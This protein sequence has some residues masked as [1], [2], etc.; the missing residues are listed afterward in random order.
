[1]PDRHDAPT[2]DEPT[3]NSVSKGLLSR[4]RLVQIGGAGLSLT[5]LGVAGA[6]AGE[7]D[8][9]NTI[10][11]D[12]TETTGP[13]SYE[14]LVTDGAAVHPDLGSN[15]S[16][17][18]IDGG[19]VTGDLGAEVHAYRFGGTLSYLDVEGAAEVSLY[20]GGGP[21][22]ATDRLEVV[23]T[24]DGEVD[25][26]I[27]STDPVTKVLSE[28]ERPA[29]ADDAVTET[30]DGTWLVDGATRNGGGDT[31]DFSG[32]IDRFEPV[33]GDF[34]LF[35]NGEETTVTELTGQ[36][37]PE[38]VEEEPA[39][40]NP[41]REH[42]YSFEAT[43]DAY[44]D[45]YIE[46]EDGGDL[47]PSTVDDATVDYEFFW[48]GDGG[49]KA[50]GRV[51]PGETHAYA[52]DTL[53][54]DVTIEGDAHPTVDG[55][56][57]GL[58]YYPRDAASGDHWKGYFPW[59]IAGEERTHWYSFEAT[60]DEYADYYIEVEDGG[61]LIP[62]T[63]DD[64]TVDYEF[65][66]IGDG[67]TKAAGRVQPGETHAYA[68]DTLVADVTI[69]GD[70]HP[71]VNGSDSGLDYYPRDSATGDAWKTGFP[72]QDGD[73]TATEPA[74][75]GVALGGGPG[76]DRIVTRAD[77]D[78]VVDGASDLASAL[79]GASA[80]DVV[81]VDGSATIDTGGRSMDV[82]DGV[83]LASN[84][85][86]DGAPGAL[87]YT[88]ETPQIMLRPQTDARVTGLRLRGHSPGRTVTYRDGI[89]F[90]TPTYALS[91][92]GGDVEVDN[93]EV[94]GWPDRAIA[95][96]R[97]RGHVHHNYIYD[98]NGQGLGY[99]VAANKECLIEY[100]YFHNNRHSVTC[101][102]NAPG[103]TARYNHFSPV[104]VMHIC[105]V[106]DP[107]EG[108][109][110][111]ESN[112]VENGESRTWDNP[113]AEGVAGYSGGFDGGSLA[114]ADNWFFDEGSAYFDSFAEVSD[115]GNV[116]GDEGAHDPTDVIANH[117]GM[118]DRP[119]L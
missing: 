15:E 28:T 94:W 84:R 80:G 24:A 22:P 1:M 44:A 27:E 7:D 101:A 18:R 88:D 109:T 116:Y 40:P 66:W 5:A 63:V 110:T 57:S 10:V 114:V 100:N 33:T 13:A 111:I 78:V 118:A 21:S 72:W 23:S 82:P 11:V 113:A 30:D 2:D 105:D 103:Y 39:D 69:E 26:R 14:F 37:A 97:S 74:P 64:A 95:V 106:H 32:S 108:D 98:N 58:D 102:Y 25:Y 60:G 35:F 62:S 29:D 117:P 61:D 119:W 112:I 50:A 53:V 8:P 115:G 86:E 34:T 70:A 31:Y 91:L 59:Q 92:E 75:D 77:A 6:S 19:H 81:F 16:G 36:E 12:G 48:I 89:S 68:F 65:F 85:G 67:G 107:F 46:V 47:I 79:S 9:S 104:S 54:A 73:R 38:E 56:D 45:Y 49:T 87:L 4:R 20:Y 90:D 96:K 55:S 99:G 42:W 43:G 93:C 52:F 83:T 51:Q 76:Y 71:T 41:D 17:D 3:E